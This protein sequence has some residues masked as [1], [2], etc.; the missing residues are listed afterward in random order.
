M[1][2]SLTDKPIAYRESVYLASNNRF[3]KIGVSN[4]IQ[5]RLHALNSKYVNKERQ[6]RLLES[7]HPVVKDR[8]IES[9]LFDCFYTFREL[10]EFYEHSNIIL[11]CFFSVRSN[12]AIQSSLQKEFLDWDYPSWVLSESKNSFEFIQNMWGELDNNIFPF[13][14]KVSK[15]TKMLCDQYPAINNWYC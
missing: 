9:F 3:L 5:P 12:A 14:I 15:K 10:G 7:F 8:I 6:F 13:G 11:N 1:V 2:N 4:N